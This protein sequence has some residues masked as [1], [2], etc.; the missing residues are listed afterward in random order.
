MIY[1]I[2]VGI[3]I[4]FNKVRGK[5]T[6]I[7]LF[8]VASLVYLSGLPDPTTTADYL[9][10]QGEYQNKLLGYTSRFEWLYQRITDATIHYNFDYSQVRLLLISIFFLVM[11]VGVYRLTK[12]AKYY[13][14]IFSL[15]L[16]FIETIQLRSFGMI[17]FVILGIS[18]LRR[19]GMLNYAVSTFF[20]FLGTGLHSSGYLFFLV[21][22]VC[23]LVKKWE[24]KTFVSALLLNSAVGTAL[25][26]SST[27]GVSVILSNLLNSISSNSES[28]DNIATLYATGF[29][30]FTILLLMVFVVP[31]IYL[32]Y[33]LKNNEFL[34]ED[35]TV[36]IVLS[37]ISVTMIG[38]PL[39]VLSNQYDRVLREGM[40]GMIILMSIINEKVSINN[41]K[42][43][44]FVSLYFIFIF[45]FIGGIQNSFVFQNILHYVHLV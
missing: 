27:T 31:L 4:F 20:I 1:L 38:I 5:W 2:V 22:L 34:L 24:I 12:N 18:F 3:N 11:F 30:L 21:P 41:K 43:I 33:L 8:L 23:F 10:Y 14:L 9:A 36:T 13:W 32:V 25:I 6:I 37:F 26:F 17:S 29:S 35:K 16:F 44:C 19:R 39:L 7:S 15:G 45:V 40:M 42:N 28:A